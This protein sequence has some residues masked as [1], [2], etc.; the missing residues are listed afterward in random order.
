[1]VDLLDFH[2]TFRQTSKG[3][4]RTMCPVQSSLMPRMA[5][6]GRFATFATGID[7]IDMDSIVRL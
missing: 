7:K 4:A 1:M 5:I 2:S 6:P 3:L